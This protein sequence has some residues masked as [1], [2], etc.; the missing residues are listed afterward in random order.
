MRL[1]PSV[2]YLPSRFQGILNPWL[3]LGILVSGVVGLYAWEY[4]QNP[5]QLPWQLGTTGFGSSGNSTSTDVLLESLTPEE[6]AVAAE[7]DNVELLLAQLDSDLSAL[8]TGGDSSAAASLNALSAGVEADAAESTVERLNRYV[9]EYRFLGTDATGSNFQTARPGQA[10][11]GQQTTPSAS[12]SQATNQTTAPSALAEAFARQ[13]AAP[14]APNSSAFSANSRGEPARGT[15]PAEAPANSDQNSPTFSFD[16]GAIDQTGV[17][18]GSLDGLNRAFIR[19]TPNMSP[20]PG[21]TGYVPP[22][23][24]PDFNRLNQ[25]AGIAPLPTQPSAGSSVPTVTAPDRSQVLPPAQNPVVTPLEVPTFDGSSQTTP[26]Q[27]RNA[28]EALWD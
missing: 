24:L 2:R 26:N 15:T 10:T 7:L 6:Q 17:T 1:P 28:W 27:P 5:G 9:D 11:V 21:T 19:T 22:A 3:W 14:A 4:R 12:T 25:A 8:T 20:P 13:Q 16:Q 23:T 18:P